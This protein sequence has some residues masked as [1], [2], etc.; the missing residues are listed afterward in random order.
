MW[1]C[2][3][4]NSWQPACNQNPYVK[5]YFTPAHE[6]HLISPQTPLNTEILYFINFLRE[7]KHHI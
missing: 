7:Q 4:K 5:H 2:I 3:K 1:K 6:P